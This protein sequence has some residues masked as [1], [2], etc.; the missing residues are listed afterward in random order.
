MYPKGIKIEKKRLMNRVLNAMSFMD[1][2]ITSSNREIEKS[3]TLF[4]D[5]F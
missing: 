2:G 1:N 5:N 3:T 4:Y